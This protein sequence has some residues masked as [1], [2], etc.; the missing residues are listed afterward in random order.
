LC[1]PSHRLVCPP[2]TSRSSS[3]FARSFPTASC[4]RKD[5]HQ[6]FAFQKACMRCHRGARARAFGRRAV[7][8]GG[9]DHRVGGEDDLG[10]RGVG[11]QTEAVRGLPAR[12]LS[13]AHLLTREGCCVNQ[14][15]PGARLGGRRAAGTPPLVWSPRGVP[16]TCRTSMIVVTACL[17][18][19]RSESPCVSCAPPEFWQACR[20]SKVPYYMVSHTTRH[21]NLRIIR[22]C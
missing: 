1:R 16:R 22:D 15:P 20:V 9:A 5:C 12:S 10:L 2:A 21:T 11:H 4:V 14:C 3:W 18:T 7:R 13:L 17:T 6:T 19:S 8:Q